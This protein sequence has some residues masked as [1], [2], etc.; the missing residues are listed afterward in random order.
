MRGGV[1]REFQLFLF[2]GGPA[3][4]SGGGDGPPGYRCRARSVKGRLPLG[5]VAAQAGGLSA[6]FGCR[7][8]RLPV[9]QPASTVGLGFSPPPLG[10]GGF[11]CQQ[12]R[13]APGIRI[14]LYG[15]CLGSSGRALGR[16]AWRPPPLLW[17]ER[18]RVMLRG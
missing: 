18:C 16:W 1:P 12:L 6:P 15:R 4:T 14:T 3:L 10:K 13:A 11:V 7:R 9:S 2:V 8:T 17:G 5:A